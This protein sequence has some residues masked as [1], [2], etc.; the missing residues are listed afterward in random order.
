MR[1]TTPRQYNN[2]SIFDKSIQYVLTKE[3]DLLFEEEGK[4]LKLKEVKGNG[5]DLKAPFSINDAKK[6]ASKKRAYLQIRK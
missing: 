6:I 4:T 5:L 2:Q 1:K 3:G